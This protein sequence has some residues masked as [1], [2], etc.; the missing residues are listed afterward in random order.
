MKKRSII[1]LFILLLLAIMFLSSSIWSIIGLSIVGFGIYHYVKKSRG[2][3]SFKR[4]LL[5]IWSGVF[6][7][8]IIVI[9]NTDTSTT[10]KAKEEARIA[11]EKEEAEAK[12]KEEARIA[13][14]KE[15]A[16][17]SN[18]LMYD[19]FGPDKNCS[20]FPSGGVEAQEF[21]IA[22]GGPA[23]DPHD[24]DRDNDGNACDWQ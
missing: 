17:V 7:A 20:D 15:E 24:L 10:E 3:P 5:I 9:A 18:N 2:K 8:F 14:E 6:L 19:P 12:A 13:A 23:S 1:L 21:Y 22:A 4:P 16:E 11:A